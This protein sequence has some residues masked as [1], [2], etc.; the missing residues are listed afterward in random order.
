MFTGII[1]AKGHIIHSHKKGGSLFLDIK[2]PA[3][4]KIAPGDSIATD[5]VCLTVAHV[6]RTAYSCEL[7]PETLAKTSFGQ[8]VPAYVNLEQALHVSDKLD[9]HFV[10]GH[11]DAIGTIKSIQSNSAGTVYVI[12]FPIK[13][14][15]LVVEKGSITVDGVGLTVVDVARDEFSVAL[16]S[17]TLTHTTLA[18]KSKGD[19][20]N[21]EFDIL[22]KYITKRLS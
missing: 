7:M 8:S 22:A 20:V 5:G 3:G 21:L 11:V 4:W 17:Y 14:N 13:F 12:S 1:K 9:G 19:F 18:D 10:L 6:A 2:K 15:H 16:V